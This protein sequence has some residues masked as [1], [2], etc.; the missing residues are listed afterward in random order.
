MLASTRSSIPRRSIPLSTCF[1]PSPSATDTSC[2]VRRALT[3]MGGRHDS[4]D[5]VGRPSASR[6]P[7][8]PAFDAA[9][10]P[11][12]VSYADRARP[13]DRSCGHDG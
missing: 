4:V 11:K 1:D 10:H 12:A 6:P 13:T 7:Q 5:A 9:Q 2:F 3:Q 8:V